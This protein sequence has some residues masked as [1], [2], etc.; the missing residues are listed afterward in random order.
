MKAR[1]GF[2]DAERRRSA[3]DNGEVDFR[4]EFADGLEG[5]RGEGSAAL[6]A[7]FTGYLEVRREIAQIRV[8]G[9]AAPP[10]AEIDP[11]GVEF[12]GEPAAGGFSTEGERGGE[13]VRPGLNLEASVLCGAMQS[14]GGAGLPDDCREV[15]GGE[16]AAE[17]ELER[18]KRECDGP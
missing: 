11:G 13:S 5:C 12:P 16:G 2:G 9:G 15:A 8:G 3:G 18:R 7:E 10:L 4:P 14:G 6:Q 17:G 1:P